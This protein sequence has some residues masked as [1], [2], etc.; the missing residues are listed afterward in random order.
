ML[1]TLLKANSG[2]AIVNC[3]DVIKEP[4]KV[5][6]SI[7]IV[8]QAPSS[9]DMLTAYENL[10]LHSLLYGVPQNIRENRILEVL[11]LVGLTDR[12]DHQ[13]RKYSGGM[14]RRLELARS[15]LHKPKVMFLDE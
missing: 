14:R 7:G 8:F 6:T 1:A 13:V 3:Y 11:Q 9:D 4:S 2:S 10:K 5:R 12:K 15:L